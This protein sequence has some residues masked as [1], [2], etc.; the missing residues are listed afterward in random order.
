MVFYSDIYNNLEK[1]ESLTWNYFYQ[2]KKNK[3]SDFHSPTF[4]TSSLEINPRTL[5][6]RD[7]NKE[8]KL[9]TF[10]TDIR[11]KK[12]K[13]IDISKKSSIHVYDKKKKI[14]VCLYGS[15]KIENRNAITKKY[16]I[17][18][19]H[20]SKLN[21][22]TKNFPDSVI[23]S[24]ANIDVLIKED[25][26]YEN[27]AVINVKIFK[28]IWLILSKKGNKKAQFV[29]KSKNKESAWLVP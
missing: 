27:F 21:Y 14:Q 3:K 15:A 29:Y 28:I 13:D 18:L 20:F 19:S 11:T 2:G 9:L 7:V 6:L 12:K 1:I 17:N 23:S 24:P 26:I 10:F 22:A 16:W 5:I 8:N 4:V 25:E